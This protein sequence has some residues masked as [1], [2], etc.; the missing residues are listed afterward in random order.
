M[1]KNNFDTI[2]PLDM[3]KELLE[4]EFYNKVEAE[5]L[6]TEKAEL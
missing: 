6:L 1:E 2:N 4:M 5:D 3:V